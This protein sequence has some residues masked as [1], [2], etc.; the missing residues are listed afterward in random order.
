LL[1]RSTS[2]FWDALWM[3]THRWEDAMM[4]DLRY[5]ARVLLKHPV[6]TLIATFT[7]ALGIGANTAIF[8]VVKAVLLNAVPCNEPERV[9]LLLIGVAGLACYIPARRAARSDPVTA[10][11]SE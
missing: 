3:Q 1:R 5:G 6:M 8:S 11:H 2:A 10:L 7:L 4:Q 9:S